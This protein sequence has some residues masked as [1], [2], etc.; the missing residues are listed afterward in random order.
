MSGGMDEEETRKRLIDKA[1]RDAG[2]QLVDYVEGGDF[3]TVAVRE[4]PTS[5]GPADFLLFVDGQAIAAV[6][7]KKIG[8]GPQN[9]LSQARRYSRG[10]RGGTLNFNGYRIPFVFSTNGKIFWF[11]DLR[12]PLSRSRET[13][14][15]H[16]SQALGALMLQKEAGWIKW[17]EENPQHHSVLRPY[18]KEA[19][20]A[21]ELALSSGKRRML[22]AM[23]T[24]TGKTIVAVSQIHRLLKSGFAKRI[25]FLVDR[26]ALAAQ[27]VGAFA[28][29]EVQPGLKFDKEYE[30]YSQRF[31]RDDLSED[32][33][34]DPKVIPTEYLVDPKYYNTFVYVCTIQ[35]MRI[36]LF[37]MEGM[38]NETYEEEGTE[39]E[40]ELLPIPIHAFDCIIADE[41]HRGYTSTEEGKWRQVLDHFDAVKIGLTATPAAHTTAYF[42]DIVYRYDYDR[43]VRE[44]YLV[45]YDAVN[46]NSEMTMKGLFLKPG[47]EVKYVDTTTG[48]AT[49]DLLEDERAFDTGEI[50]RKA[51]AVDRNR[52]VV[53]EFAKYARNYQKEFGHFPKTLFFAVNDLPHVSHADQVVNL[54]RD[55]FERGDAFV[56]KITGSPTVDRPLK[57]IREFRNR[58]E[59]AIA[60]T[61]DMLTTGIDVPRIENLVFL[62]PVRSRILFA[63]MLGR[64]TRRC[65]EI[66]KTHFTVFDCFNGTLLEYFR[67]TTDFTSDPPAKPTRTNHD[68]IESIYGNKDREYNLKL[69]IRRLQRIE[70]SVSAEGR[71]QF[72][73]F[74]SDGDIGGFARSL[75]EKLQTDWAATMKTLRNPAFQEVL[76]SYSRAV[77]EFVVTESAEDTVSSEYMFRTTD[78]RELKPKDYLV[79]FERFVKGNPDHIDALSIL[80]RR[81]ASFHTK[82]LS[83]LR[84]KLAARPE[85]F[86]EQNLRRAY[87][88][89][90]ADII[91]IIKHAAKGEPLVS[92]Q[93]RVE[94]AVAKVKRGKKFTPLQEK[95]LEM[96]KDHLLKNSVIDRPDFAT[97]PFS[98]HGGWDKANEVFNGKL[99]PLLQT[100]DLEM[101]K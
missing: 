19:I 64:G 28:S 42:N 48:E 63:Q 78:G 98:R 51:T 33:K 7:A 5:G 21:T 6:E 87:Q 58:P 49:Y 54:L 53:K 3:E 15:F 9:V 31:R 61:V 17:F 91:S 22:L 30:V 94:R 59:P 89:D 35:R 92:S 39:D 41:C 96:I 16:T 20:E 80:L 37:G 29:F 76:E 18:Q 45:D 50:E 101:V 81:P 52:K 62:R 43:A 79:A 88:N 36:N 71:E 12:N 77:K 69:L 55:E 90:L 34:F 32:Y 8:I 68:I 99:A 40:A 60:V 97:I 26:R 56:E 74:I 84:K 86:T 93:A 82:E 11:Q 73:N 65:D 25:L 83:D 14:G 72:A 13:S 44:G 1:L 67:R 100:I 57:R 24:G 47:D 2:W 66:G 27:A 75:P 70:K 23:A 85:K 95:W 38:F 4:H 10:Y 46:I